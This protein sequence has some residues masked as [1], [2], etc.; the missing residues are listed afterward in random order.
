MPPRLIGLRTDDSFWGLNIEN[1]N[2]DFEDK[3]ILGLESTDS[4]A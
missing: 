3:D 4:D 2:F 1:K